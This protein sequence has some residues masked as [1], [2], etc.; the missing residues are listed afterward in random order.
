MIDEL[1]QIYKLG[2]LL[3]IADVPKSTYEY[4]KTNEYIKRKEIRN[5]EDKQI[6]DKI[7]DIYK[8]NFG[9]YG[10]IR[11]TLELRKTMLINQKKVERIMHK[12]GLKGIQGS[13]QKYHSYY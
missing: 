9:R 13:N 12:Y 1:R 7:Y 5:Q 4:H 10:Y 11:I 3:K 2:V 6:Y 8:D